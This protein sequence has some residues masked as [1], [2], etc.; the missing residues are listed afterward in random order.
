MYVILN[1]DTR[2]KLGPES[3]GAYCRDITPYVK[4]SPFLALET[5]NGSKV[6][7]RS[8]GVHLLDIY[9]LETFFKRFT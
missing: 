8:N 4:V 2:F 1:I 6:F 7:G 5:A 9:Q 3:L